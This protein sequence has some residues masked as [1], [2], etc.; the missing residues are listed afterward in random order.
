MPNS[1]DLNGLIL[2]GGK[3]TRMGKD[4]FAIDYHGQPEWHRIKELLAPYVIS[5]HVS[6]SPQQAEDFTGVDTIVDRWQDIGPING[7]AS[8]LQTY[9][10]HAWLVIACDMPG[11]TANTID[12]LL[13]A[14]NPKADATL[15]TDP[16]GNFEPLCAIY[17]PSI[18]PAF[19][20]AIDAGNH[21]LNRCLRACNTHTVVLDDP[22]ALH[23]I[24][25]P[26][27]SES[28]KNNQVN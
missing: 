26:Q 23:N 13:N 17:E 8:A 27:E 9:P 28:Y 20:S 3:S 18:L 16:R 10:D 2:V 22:N 11:L 1:A 7:I 4:K 5:T 6:V 24:N 15:Y 21:G 14:R 25:T 19:L 12:R